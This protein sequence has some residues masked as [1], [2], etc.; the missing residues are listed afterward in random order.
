MRRSSLIFDRNLQWFKGRHHDHDQMLCCHFWS[1]PGHATLMTL[2]RPLMAAAAA[3][4]PRLQG[5]LLATCS[6]RR[7]SDHR[8]WYTFWLSLGAI[9]I[10]HFTL[11]GKCSSFRFDC[12]RT[13]C[14]HFQ[15]HLSKR[16]SANA[17][18]VAISV[19][20]WHP[21]TGLMFASCG[22]YEI[23]VGGR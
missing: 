12:V 18:L 10:R 5:S 22:C 20:I 8:I 13:P 19:W 14:I 2:D 23:L 11:D 17:G 7:G 16:N 4:V 1:K 9:V 21:F 6:S 3:Q 15:T